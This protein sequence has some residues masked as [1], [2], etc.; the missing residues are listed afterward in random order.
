M[1]HFTVLVIG[2][3]PDEQ[4]AQ[5]EEFE[6]SG[7]ESPYIQ[8]LDITDTTL[9]EYRAWKEGCENG[10]TTFMAWRTDQ[11]DVIHGDAEPDRKRAHKYGWVRFASK[12]DVL[13]TEVVRRTNPNSKWD[14]YQLGGR[15]GQFFTLKRNNNDGSPECADEARKGQIDFDAMRDVAEAEA[16]KKYRA[17][18]DVTK[19]HTMPVWSEFR[20]AFEDINAARDAYNSLEV[21]KALHAYPGHSFAWMSDEEVQ[22]LLLDEVEFRALVRHRACATFAVLDHGKWKERAEMGWFGCEHDATMTRDE[23]AR[24]INARLDELP[25]DTLLGVYDCRF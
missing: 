7:T 16:M 22:Q 23:W 13:P 2:D 17:F 6:C 25:D 10:P 1:R 9:N 8:E 4:L 18:Q 15:W 21:I 3:N 11:S 19:G 24:V 14:W 5:F 20:Q 12:D